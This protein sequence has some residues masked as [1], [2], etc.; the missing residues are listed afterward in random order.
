MIILSRKN[1][2][3]IQFDRIREILEAAT[4]GVISYGGEVEPGETLSELVTQVDNTV[5]G[6]MRDVDGLQYAYGNL[7]LEAAALATQCAMQEQILDS[8]MEV[9]FDESLDDASTDLMDAFL[10]SGAATSTF[11]GD[12]SFDPTVTFSKQDIKPL[13]RQAIITWI[14]SKVR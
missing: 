9:G 4:D 5:V 6:Y 2:D 12:I 7:Q 1:E 10:G 3:Q 14:T 11:D 8:V 13:L